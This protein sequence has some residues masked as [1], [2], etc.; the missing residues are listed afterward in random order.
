MTTIEPISRSILVLRGH[1]ILLDANLAD[2]YGV[3]PKALLE[4]IKR[5]A[6]RFPEDFMFQLTA[7]EWDAVTSKP[8]R[9]GRSY[10][11]YA[12]TDN[13]VAMLSSVLHSERAI[14]ANIQV[15]R[16]LARMRALINTDSD[17]ARR[18]TQFETRLYKKLVTRDEALIT[19]LTA[20]RKL[21]P[22]PL[23][24]RLPFEI[25]PE[26]DEMP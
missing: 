25:P 15:I 2:L 1:K 12:F 14:T 3:A 24:K 23:P 16:V 9:A 26:T 20:I 17:L 21:M 10:L 4:A 18:L 11:P 13:G 19:I 6:Q 22:K 7:D 8:Q 5:N